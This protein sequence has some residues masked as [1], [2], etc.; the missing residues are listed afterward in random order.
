MKRVIVPF[1][2]GLLTGC[3]TYID[4]MSINAPPKVMSP[5]PKDQVQ[6]FKSAKPPRPFVEV[7]VLKVGMASG[8]SGADELQIL[9]DARAEA[10]RRGCDGL[11][12]T[13]SRKMASGT[14]YHGTYSST[15]TVNERVSGITASCVVFTDEK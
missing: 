6:V 13:D 4:Y 15:I 9:D 2:F 12:V 10:G 8:F 14:G 7:G 3:G 11:M 5:R 1:L